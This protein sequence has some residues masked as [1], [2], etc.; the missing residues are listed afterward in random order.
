MA[1]VNYR[2]RYIEQNTEVGS[3]MRSSGDGSLY[4]KLI[5]L[6]EDYYNFAND[7]MKLNKDSYKRV[8]NGAKKETEGIM[9]IRLQ[10]MIVR[11]YVEVSKLLVVVMQTIGVPRPP[12]EVEVDLELEKRNKNIDVRKELDRIERVVKNSARRGIQI[13]LG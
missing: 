10:T 5:N 2:R 8:L 9:P 11:D 1:I 3:V 13:P 12:E 4:E 7:L 6:S